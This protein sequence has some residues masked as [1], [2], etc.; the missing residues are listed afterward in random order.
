L[1]LWHS[2]YQGDERWSKP[3][4]ASVYGNDDN[5]TNPT[6]TII[7]GNTIVAAW[8]GSQIYEIFVMTGTITDT[9]PVSPVPWQKPTPTLDQSSILPT[10]GIE[11]FE[12]EATIIPEFDNNRTPSNPGN[13]VYLSIILPIVVILTAVINRNRKIRK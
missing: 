13:V 8:Y 11:N 2:I 4:I 3:T 6:V 12:F 10:N 7:N 5:M 9:P 1:G